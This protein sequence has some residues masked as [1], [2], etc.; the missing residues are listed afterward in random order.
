[1]LRDPTSQRITPTLD[2]VSGGRD[3]RTNA[4]LLETALNS[5]RAAERAIAIARESRRDDGQTLE[6]LL[7][8]RDRLIKAIDGFT[9]VRKG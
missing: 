9:R 6:S 7:E 5:L 1:M 3:G 8:A 2:A 4:N